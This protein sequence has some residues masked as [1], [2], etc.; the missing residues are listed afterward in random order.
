MSLRERTRPGF[1]AKRSHHMRFRLLLALLILTSSVHAAK[2]DDWEECKKV[3]GDEAACDRLIASGTLKGR[4]L[5]G[6]YTARGMARDDKRDLDGAIADYDQAIKLDPKQGFTYRVRS[7]VRHEKGDLEGA[8][9]DYNQSV[10]LNPELS[11]PFFAIVLA[12]D[13]SKRKD[14]AAALTIYRPLADQG[15]AVAQTN[16]GVMYENGEGVTQDDTEAVRLYRL[17]ADQGLAAAQFQLSRK[18]FSGEGVPRNPAEGVRLCLLAARQDDANA[19]RSMGI[20]YL[21]GLNGVTQNYAESVK[22][23]TLAAEQGLPSAQ[24]ELG[25]LYASGT[26]V[27]QDYVRAHMW[28]NLS[29]AQGYERAINYRDK[30]ASQMTPEQIA[31]A[32]KLAREWK[33]RKPRSK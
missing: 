2:A 28:F 25:N 17:A 20:L 8:I 1:S 32:Q 30:I 22:W 29:A 19:E 16:L 9:A 6:A 11:F 13:A 26:G 31:E 23:Y 7:L 24:S 21:S 15:N 14:Y 12:N 5:V 10:A 3:K 18:Y 4:D 33:P 27:P